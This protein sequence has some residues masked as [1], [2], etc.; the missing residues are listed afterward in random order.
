[1]QNSKPPNIDR[2]KYKPHEPNGALQIKFSLILVALSDKKS[3]GT[4]PEL[5]KASPST[6]SPLSPLTFF[7]FSRQLACTHLCSL[8]EKGIMGEKCTPIIQNTKHLVS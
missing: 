8:K 4:F 7:Q 2:L 1:M 6:F 3:I 5:Q